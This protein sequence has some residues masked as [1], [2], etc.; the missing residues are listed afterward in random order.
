[1]WCVLYRESSCSISRLE[2]YEC[3]DGGNAEK[4]DKTLRK[5]Q[6]HKKVQQT[7]LDSTVF[8]LLLCRACRRSAAVRLLLPDV[9]LAL[10]LLFV[11]SASFQVITI[12]IMHAGT[13]V[14]VCVYVRVLGDPSGGLYPGDGGGD[15]GMS[16]R[17]RVLPGGDHGEDLRV[18]RRQEPSG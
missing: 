12:A 4:N 3:K 16:Q 10:S 14:I 1:M 15:G 5:Q 7:L 9:T 8:F 17:H 11:G 6:E 13:Q 2:F 18:R